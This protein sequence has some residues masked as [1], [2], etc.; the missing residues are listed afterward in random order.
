[1]NISVYAKSMFDFAKQMQGE[2]P[3]CNFYYDEDNIEKADIIWGNYPPEKLKKLPNL[4]WLQ[5][6]MAGA[7][8]YKPEL[9]PSNFILTSASGAYTLSIAE[10]ML[11]GQ[12]AL[13]RNLHIFRDLQKEHVWKKA[14]PVRSVKNSTV[15][16]YGIGSIGLA[17]AKLVKA[18][19]ATVLG[20]RRTNAEKPPFVDEVFLADNFE[21]ALA[22]ADVIAI[23]AP[24]TPKTANV[25]NDDTFAKIKDG[26]VLINV[27][28]G[29][30]VDTNALVNAL[31]NGK[32]SGAVLDV[33]YPEPLPKEHPLWDMQ[34]VILTSHTSGGYGIKETEQI[35]RDI[36]YENLKNYLDNKP[37]INVI[38][39]NEGY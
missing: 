38:D 12:L 13:Y 10:Y 29:T 5:M 17:Y 6:T 35:K 24:G 22:R 28:R 4:K 8:I 15:L 7:N 2:F 30:I 33:V 1:M 27:G 18:L 37:L 21:S 31:Q 26:A 34:N 25:F 19:G 16:I 23:S 39:I 9:C 11:A 14:G 20:V 36:F 3:D 32:L